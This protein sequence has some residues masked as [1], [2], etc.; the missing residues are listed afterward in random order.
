MNSLKKTFLA[1]LFF[2]GAFSAVFAAD[3]S[4]SALEQIACH[5]QISIEEVIYEIETG[6]IELEEEGNDLRVR[7]DGG[8][9]QIILQDEG[10]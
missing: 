7:R 9:V 1:L 8:G 2:L 6:I 10:L 5:Y 4:Q 3:P